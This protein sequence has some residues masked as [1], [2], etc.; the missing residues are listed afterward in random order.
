MYVK[1]DAGVK[2][3]PV[4]MCLLME[5]P[6]NLLFTKLNPSV[7]RLFSIPLSQP[8]V[9]NISVSK[10]SVFLG[11]RCLLS[12]GNFLAASIQSLIF[13]TWTLCVPRGT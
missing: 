3:L 12:R 4:G 5:F 11:V 8:S 1:T 9:A 7:F 6:G 10:S 13:W 2:S